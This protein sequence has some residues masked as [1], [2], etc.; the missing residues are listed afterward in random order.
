MSK[1]YI[2]VPGTTTLLVCVLDR[3][4]REHL[5][6]APIRHPG[7]T[8]QHASD[9][10]VPDGAG[11]EYER[12]VYLGGARAEGP[13]RVGLESFMEIRIN[14]IKT[15][16]TALPSHGSELWTIVVWAKTP[17]RNVGPSVYIYDE[18]DNHLFLSEQQPEHTPR[19]I[20]LWWGQMLTVEPR[21]L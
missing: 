20:E 5:K 11:Y 6:F 16:W 13:T 7:W 14:A 21:D 2:R 3:I 15:N 4:L 18:R 8:F 10:T 17:G 19:K 9:H 12:S 1:E